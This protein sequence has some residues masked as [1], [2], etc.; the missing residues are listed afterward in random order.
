MLSIKE[1]IKTQAIKLG[2]NEQLNGSGS[3]IQV[4]NE[5][6]TKFRANSKDTENIIEKEQKI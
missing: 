5:I 3:E 4:F 1:W 6:L 2:V